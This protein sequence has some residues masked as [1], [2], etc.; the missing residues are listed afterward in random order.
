MVSRRV[1]LIED[2]K[3][4][5]SVY[6][7]YLIELGHK[8]V[9]E[10]TDATNA[11]EEIEET[12][13]EIVLMDIHL[14]GKING[15][16]ATDII[17][18]Q[19]DIPVIY[20]S[21]Y[22]D[23]T[24]ISKAIE[25]NAYGYLIK[26]ID[27]TSLRITID[28]VYSKHRFERISKLNEHLIDNIEVA[29]IGLNLLGK[30]TYWNKGAEKLFGLTPDFILGKDFSLIIPNQPE[31][32][33]QE[34]IIEPVLTREHLEIS[35]SAPNDKYEIIPIILNFTLN[36]QKNDVL[37]IICNAQPNLNTSFNDS[38]NYITT[39]GSIFNNIP[40]SLVI[41]N[42]KFYIEKANIASTKLLDYLYKKNIDYNKGFFENY[43]FFNQVDLSNLF[44]NSFNGVTH[45]LERTYRINNSILNLELI[46]FPIFNE[47][48]NDINKICI[49]IRDITEIKNLEREL[50]EVKNEIKPLFDSSIQR[51]YLCDLNYKL[52]AF[53]KAAKDVIIKEKNHLLKKGDSIIDFVPEEV[54]IQNFEKLFNDAKKGLNVVFKN[55]IIVKGDTYWLETHIDPVLN[56]KGEIYRVLVWTMDITERETQI[57]ELRETQDRYML[58]AKG[59]NDGIW[60]W[61]IIK[62]EVYL[63]PRWKNVLG[64]EDHELK[65]EFGTRDSLIH[66][67]DLTKSKEILD[68]YLAGETNEYLNEI[69]LRHKN[70]NYIWVIERGALLS[71]Y[72]GNP[73]RL[74]G[75]ITDITTLKKIETELRS[76]NRMLLEERNMFMQG[77]VVIAR[78][79]IGGGNNT[80]YISDNVTNML[81][82][83]PDEF[84][85]NNIS[86]DKLI[87]PDDYNLHINE[88]E[89]AIK[90]GLSHV[91]YSPYRIMSKDNQSI[92][93]KDFASFIKNDKN[94]VVEVLG[95]FVDI[96]SEKKWEE[97]LYENQ[98]KYYILFNEANDGLFIIENDI[99][100][101]CNSKMT[102]IFG[103]T[104]DELIGKKAII[105]SPEN[106][107]DGT[108]S[109]I[110][111]LKKIKE[112]IEENKTTIYWQYRKKDGSLFDS[113]ASLSKI[114]IE[115]KSYIHVSIRDISERKKIER[116]LKISEQKYKNLLNSIP[117]L[118]FIIDVNGI[119]KYFKPD[120]KHQ[121]AVPDNKI[122]GKNVSMFF[123]GEKLAEIINKIK[124]AIESNQVQTITYQLNSPQGLQDFEGRISPIGADEV[125]M[126]VR[127]LYQN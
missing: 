55:R 73:L 59:G 23:D 18:K 83:T 61:D 29:I 120:Y 42:N 39:F 122:V 33:V 71:D 7:M 27:K 11:I 16:E 76:T 104:R 84:Y 65:N 116:S 106:Q 66:P 43:P 80:L 22:T 51:F 70:G 56:D 50:N 101:D 90:D 69:R 17:Q 93:V 34:H 31:G 48:D 2:D 86:Y 21:S 125:L 97:A 113:E 103:Y 91:E 123:T 94:E 28:L 1:L 53:N 81:G 12:L 62:N 127:I 124:A 45:F 102:E 46:V 119:Y 67:E 15:I 118:I 47:I 41:L 37:G 115:S 105:L 114:T 110:K 36:K 121:L 54:T 35:L 85:K 100:T 74:A 88:R 64:Y 63:S 40:Q 68:K 60:D 87:N 26:P 25:T 75:S 24:T 52:V 117:D 14:P 38:F 95:Y 92:W 79:K 99:I 19:Y 5:L 109:D 89:K 32:Y 78:M 44:D 98:K 111:R 57:M 6:S 8:V 20:I 107:P 126:I 77:N 10:Y 30:I 4:L 9:G 96:T 58:V 108:P 82:Y 13:P 49:S 72:V 3:M 112:A